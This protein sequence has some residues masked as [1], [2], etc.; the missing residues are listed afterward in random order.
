MVTK[1]NGAVGAGESLGRDLD[2]FV[3]AGPVNILVNGDLQGN[4]NA[5][6]TGTTASQAKLD[7]LVEVISL[8]GQPIIRAKPTTDGTTYTMKFATEHTGAWT[9]ADLKAAVIAHHADYMAA[10]ASLITVSVSSNLS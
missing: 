2:F 9:A 3:F 6:N 5:A 8:R 10:N 7:K 4:G 1:V